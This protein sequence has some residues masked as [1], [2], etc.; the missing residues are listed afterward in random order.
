MQ[1]NEPY[2]LRWPPISKRDV[3]VVMKTLLNKDISISDGSGIIAEF[4][5]DFAKWLGI[6]YCLAQ[7]SGTSTLHSAFFAIGIKEG[8]EVLVPS[9]TWHSSV[10]PLLHLR[11]VPVFCEIDPATLTIDPDDIKKRITPKTKAILVVHLFGMP[12]EM[13]KIMTIAR[14]HNLLVV[15]DCSHAYGSLY[16]GKCVGTFG[17]I[18]C[19]S[20]QASKMLPA[21][22]GGIFCTNKKEYYEKALLLG[23]FGRL[24]ELSKNDYKRFANTGL[25][26]KYRPHPLAIALAKSQLRTINRR[27]RN[28]NKNIN[29]FESLLKNIPGISIINKPDYCNFKSNYG[30]RFIYDENETGISK[31]DFIK[32]LR[33]AG[34]PAHDECYNLL[35]KEP[36]FQNSQFFHLPHRDYSLPI[37]EKAHSKIICINL[38]YNQ[39]P[40]LI[41]GYYETMRN[42]ISTKTAYRQL[43]VG[44]GVFS[45]PDQITIELTMGCNLHCPMCYQRDFRRMH[46]NS[47]DEMSVESIEKLLVDVMPKRVTLSGGEPTTKNGF[48][49]ILDTLKKLGIRFTILTNGSLF[50]EQ[51]IN[52]I[53]EYQGLGDIVFS[54]D[55]YDEERHDSWRGK[56]GLFKRIIN[57]VDKL[58]NHFTT[59][60]AAVVLEDN[61]DDLIKL[62]ED[63]SSRNVHISLIPY[64]QYW[65]KEITVTRKRLSTIFQKDEDS[66]SLMVAAQDM[67]CEKMK[68]NL[69]ILKGKQ[70]KRNNAAF[71]PSDLPNAIND[72][73]R[74]ENVKGI[75][76]NLR[77]SR[78]RVDSKG[79]VIVCRIIRETLGDLGSQSAKEIWDSEKYKRLRKDYIKNGPY[80]ICKRCPHFIR[81]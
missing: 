69:Q 57:A 26:F 43:S 14:K 5:S 67:D 24:N 33:E 10:S 64:E 8:D 18:S 6:K 63:Y 41:N 27:I 3:Y 21:G 42:V 62:I 25:G 34:I 68:K 38:P 37:T 28:T 17:D 22:E 55:Y 50:D 16:K 75:C 23:H 1:S 52:K 20:M 36:I 29:Q 35:H 44:K 80:P 4:E 54:L 19:F 32:S 73:Y 72:F 13:D 59:C 46:D 12:A 15:E 2:S 76:K 74:M 45:T 78:L 51:F 61:L 31:T 39:H 70:D 7:N 11:A 30:F 66:F 77:D 79:K 9:L 71:H 40:N 58:E 47:M 81:E 60:I 65:E 48:F 53:K 56:K 49:R